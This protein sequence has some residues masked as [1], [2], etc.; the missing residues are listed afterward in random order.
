MAQPLGAAYKQTAGRW[1]EE[2]G[3]FLL[4][5][6]LRTGKFYEIKS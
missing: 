4:L 6:R 2:D 3:R 5:K 1:L